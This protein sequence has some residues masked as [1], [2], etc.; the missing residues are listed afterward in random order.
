MWTFLVNGNHCYTFFFLVTKEIKPC[1]CG[2]A[3]GSY[4][5]KWPVIFCFWVHERES[6]SDDEKQVKI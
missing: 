4:K 1:K 5:R 2:E 6:I 3:E